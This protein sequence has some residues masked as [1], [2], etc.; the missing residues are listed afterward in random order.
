MTITAIEL[1]VERFQA[2]TLPK[3]EWTHEAHLIVALWHLKE[4][5]K[6]TATC[7][8]RAGII[9]YNLAVGTPNT[10]NSGYHE[11]ITLFWIRLMGLFVE[12]NK[13][14]NMSELVTKFLLSGYAKPAI[15]FDYYSKDLLFSTA[16]RANWVKP[17][18]RSIGD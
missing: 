12:K 11:T 13:E 9:N 8:L 10:G 2:R 16:A 17:D 4:Y 6:D 14:L 18:I 5:D 1:L 7:L 3:E 15:L